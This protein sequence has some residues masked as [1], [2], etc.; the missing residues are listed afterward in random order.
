LRAFLALE[1]PDQAIIERLILLEEELAR[2]QSDV[3]IVGKENLHFTVKFFGEIGEVEVQEIDRRLS[4]LKM[5]GQNVTVMGLGSFPDIRRPSVVWVG[6]AKEDEKKLISLAEL[7]IDSVKEIGRQEDHEYHPHIT[8]ARLK[9]GRN[10]DALLSFIQKNSNLEFGRV[11]LNKLKLKSS[12]LTPRG[13]IYSDVH[14]YD[15]T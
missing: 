5:Q 9:S 7:L 12:V 15:L 10:K 4:D 6:V 8:I 14:E 13:P 2:T 1:I 3:K 11:R